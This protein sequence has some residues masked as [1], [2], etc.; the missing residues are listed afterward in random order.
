MRRWLL[1][2][3]ASLCFLG[4]VT[5]RA[6]SMK[7]SDLEEMCKTNNDTCRFFIWGLAQGFGMREVMADQRVN[8]QFVARKPVVFCL[9]ETE[10]VNT[11][12]LKFKLKLAED[13]VVFPNDRSQ[14]AEGFA[15]GILIS[16][17]PC[18]G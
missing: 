3:M 18:K 14:G 4:T 16:L 7:V 5:A 2:A 6:D 13:L 11:L 15:V 17:F 10:T 12:A 1:G 9:P 8:G